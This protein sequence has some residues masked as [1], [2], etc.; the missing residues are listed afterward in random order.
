MPDPQYK[1]SVLPEDDLIEVVLR[2]PSG[3]KWEYGIPFNRSTGTFDFEDIKV[4]EL[5]FGEQFAEKMIGDI[6]SAVRAAIA[7][8]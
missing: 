6:R 2:A 5:D 3:D 7:G 8:A 4:I 1:I